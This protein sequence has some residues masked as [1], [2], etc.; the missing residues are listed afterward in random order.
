M[1]ERNFYRLDP[2]T[3]RQQ[4]F[5]RL[6]GFLKHYVQPYHPHFRDSLKKQGV[7]VEHVRTYKDFCSLSVVS[8][9]DYRVDPRAFVLQPKFPGREQLVPYDTAPIDKMNLMKYIARAV[10]NW[11]KDYSSYFRKNRFKED[12]VG[13]RVA[14]E[15]M[16]IHFHGSSG[17]TGDP[18]PAVYTTYDIFNPI[19]EMAHFTFIRPDVMDPNRKY[20]ELTD[21]LMNLFPGMPHLAFFQTVISKF[22][23]GMC[24]FDTGGG[25]VMPTERQIEV[26]ASQNFTGLSAIPSYFTHWI[27]KA[28]EAKEAG[29]IKGLN[30][31]FAVVLGGE[32]ASD[33]LKDYFREMAKRAGARSDFHVIESYGMTEMKW[34]FMECHE[35]SGIHLN[36]KYFY[37]ETLDPKTLEP[38]GEGKP[39]L[40]VFSHIGWRGTMFVRYNTGDIA[41]GGIRWQT[42]D[43]CGYTFP[44]L[45]GPLYRAAKDFTKIKGTRVSLPE[46]VRIIRD[47]PGVRNFQI[48]LDKET[49]GDELSRDF[50]RL[51]ILPESDCDNEILRLRLTRMV[52]TYLEITPNEFLFE[53]DEERFSAELFAKTGIKAEYIVDLRPQPKRE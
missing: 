20:V 53:T 29:K 44:I 19:K 41:A 12:K 3:Q 27:R 24:S 30:E 43:H 6:R 38:V 25:A 15:W 5:Q 39:G 2:Q 52:K 40:V 10:L 35:G 18:T 9:A 28:V 17:T 14:W 1:S 34:A 4:S 8:K 36:P 50:V 49:S 31:L 32:G 46:F 47:E 45:R 13:R 37:W 22:M 33:T 7:S 48:V 42:C 16:P 26:F 51:R 11:P 21:R 23:L